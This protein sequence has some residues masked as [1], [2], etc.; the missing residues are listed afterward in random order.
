MSQQSLF[1][2]ASP[3][4]SAVDAAPLPPSPVDSPMPPQIPAEWLEAAVRACFL[5]SQK[6][7]WAA[8]STEQQDE[9]GRAL[10]TYATARHRSMELPGLALHAEA[11]LF[12]WL[13][14]DPELAAAVHVLNA[15]CVN[16]ADVPLLRSS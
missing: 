2:D 11:A 10:W 3:T 9:V 8:L 16:T 4:S 6:K 7:R 15:N 1:E 14:A 5:Q 13:A 12:G